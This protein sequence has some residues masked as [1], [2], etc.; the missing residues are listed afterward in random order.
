MSHKW[1]KKY[2]VTW[3]Y[4]VYSR[5]RQSEIIQTCYVNIFVRDHISNSKL[6]WLLLPILCIWSSLSMSCTPTMYFDF[7]FCVSGVGLVTSRASSSHF[8][9]IYICS[10]KYQAR[11]FERPAGIIVKHWLILHWAWFGHVTE[12]LRKQSLKSGTRAKIL[13]RDSSH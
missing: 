3:T 13:F 9:R 5:Y 1:Q 12:L 10:Y 6:T 8:S 4:Y 2:D 11:S 7:G